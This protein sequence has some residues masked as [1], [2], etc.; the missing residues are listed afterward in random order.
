M[1]RIN[2]LRKLLNQYNYEYY[3]L[4]QSSVSDMEYDKLMKE[5]IALEQANPSYQDPLSPSVRVGSSISDKFDKVAH[6]HPM[7][8]LS[9]VYDEQEVTSFV[10]K[11][12]KVSPQA[13][14][15]SEC[16]IDGLAMSLHYE[17]GRLVQALTR[18]D[19]EIGEDVTNNV[20]MINS[21]PLILK[22]PVSLEVRGEIYLP[23]A[24][25]VL[26]NANRSE[27]DK[28]M[29]CRNVASGTIRQLD[30]K[31]VKKRGLDAFWYQLV[32]FE[33]YGLTN[34]LQALDYLASLGFK[35]NPNKALCKDAKELW[36]FISDIGNQRSSLPYDIDGVV[37]KVNQY[38]LQ[39]QLG[40]TAKSPKW[41][42][43]YKFPAQ[44]V[45][46]R[47]LDIQLSVGRTGKIT[48]NAVLARVEVAG[49]NVEAAQLHNEDYI[50]ERDLRINDMVY[51]RKAGDIIP[52]VIKVDMTYRQ[53]QQ[54]YVFPTTCPKCDSTLVRAKGEAAHY[55]LNSDCPARLV[56]S[57]VHFVSR[58][59]MN[60]DSLGER[61]IE[62]FYNEGLISKV[63]DIYD[64][65]NKRAMIA[66][67]EGWQAKS[68]D[69][70]LQA[71][72]TSKANSLEKLIY[73]LGIRNIGSKT[74]KTLAKH[75]KTLDALLTSN[76]A[77]L[78]SINDVGEITANS[79]IDYAN[80]ESNQH[81]VA[82]L[83]A[84]GVNTT[85]LGDDEVVASSFTDKTIV[86]TGTFSEFNRK[87]LQANLEKLGA[88]VTGSVT[89]KT[90][91]VV[92]GE[93]AG[94]KLTKAESLG[95]AT[96]DE[97]TLIE[98]LSKYA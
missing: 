77:E 21:I 61:S 49:T 53:D 84:S 29:N 64:L 91:L 93:A 13:S 15:V 79:I 94:S 82:C 58:N 10:E 25:L 22:E 46:T 96:M 65:V 85:Y 89:K 56:E 9:N 33:T 40:F 12:Q 57:L 42:T 3:V 50:K 32:N 4:N 27:E 20:K 24:Q 98:E 23:K 54:P 69:K 78:A 19:G 90:D 2:E 72:E 81:L 63:E 73:A 38:T 18:G 62:Q 47:L 92:H 1:E 28:F 45:V 30:N 55:C 70:L 11:I 80:V 75:F 8:S 17:D 14:F 88:K 52:E 86:I 67:L 16:K 48:P 26:L 71:I 59:A 41:A 31:I 35:V 6:K 39:Q 83:K 34:H 37:I 76:L 51:I 95:V 87:E 44:E 74:A 5:L 60:I 97:A 7:L 36:S 43:A 68:I 66:N